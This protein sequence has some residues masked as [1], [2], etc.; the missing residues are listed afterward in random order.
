AVAKTWSSAEPDTELSYA[1][2]LA[3]GNILAQVRRAKSQ[4]GAAGADSVVEMKQD[5][6]VVWKYSDRARLLHHDM[7]RTPNGN[8]LLVCSKDLDAPQISRTLVTDDR[9]D[10]VDR[11]EKFVWQWQTPD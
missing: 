8:T 6:R 1:R 9:L 4:S 11:P 7:E 5:D 10:E 2:P 3:N